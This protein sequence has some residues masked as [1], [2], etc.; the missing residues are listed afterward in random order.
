M[1]PAETTTDEYISRDDETEA[2]R[3][4]AMQDLG[5]VVMIDPDVVRQYSMSD[6]GLGIENDI[7]R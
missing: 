2:N 6:F 1:N 7:S 5:D 3:L 4:T